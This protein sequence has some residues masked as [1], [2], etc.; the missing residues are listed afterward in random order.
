MAIACNSQEGPI[1]LD[2]DGPSG[3]DLLRDLLIPPTREA[4]SRKGRR[5]LYFDPALDN[6]VV[7][8]TIKLKRNGVK[9]DLDVLGDGGYVIAPPSIHPETG[10]PYAWTFKRSVVPL[11]PIIP[12]LLQRSD[13]RQAA[14][15]LPRIIHEGQRDALLTS[16]AGS[17][18]R[19]NA[20]ESAILAALRK[21]NDQRLEPPLPDKQLQ[22][23]AKSIA[24]KA[25]AGLGEHFTDLGNA[26]RFILQHHDQVRSTSIGRQPWMIWDGVRWTDAVG[27]EVMRL[28]KSTV[29]SLYLEAAHC[30]DVD[31]REAILKHASKSESS[32]SLHALLRLAESEPEIATT[33]DMLDADHWLFNVENGTVD[34]RTGTLRPHDRNDL[35]TRLAPVTFDPDEEAPR[36]QQFLDDITN[37]NLELQVF[38]QRA[39]GYAMTGETRE[40][41]LFFC[42]GKGSNGKSTFLETIRALFGEYAQQADFTTFLARRSEGPRNDLARM[43][44]ARLVTAI[45]A[46]GDRS[47]DET[48]LKQLTGSD[49]IIARRLYEEFFEFRPQHKLFLAANHKPIVKEQT[50]AFWR[51]IKLIPFIVTFAKEKRDKKL[52][53]KLLRELSGILNWAI[54]GCRAWQ[55]EGLAE[56][57]TVLQAT[58]SYREENDLLGEFTA[59]V[60]RMDETAWTSTPDLY[61]AFSEWWLNTRGPRS[62][63]PS[64][65]WFGRLLGE[66]PDLKPT[67]K[68]RLRGWRGIAIKREVV[69]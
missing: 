7:P 68:H 44:G 57:K 18:R 3:N 1:V 39:I 21:E 33:S 6:A 26:R 5:H 47:F 28:A 54:A 62:T 17:M 32:V 37:H 50:E 61:R 24:K 4:Q 19:R 31:E 8:R 11:P 29:R 45:E 46:H 35:I 27:G 55:R 48:V 66:R 51:R 30:Q 63:P 36:W 60:C 25:P 12:Q 22:K 59:I 58:T 41:C 52:D 43:R 64:M 10:K 67:K 38:L 9:Y 56:P 23:I 16:L 20:S 53:V 49:T 40:Q 2:V 65:A 69:T 14:E 42:W 34:L 15:P 13:H